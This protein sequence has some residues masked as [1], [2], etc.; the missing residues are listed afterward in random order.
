MQDDRLDIDVKDWVKKIRYEFSY[1]ED[2]MI[3]YR[4]DN[5]DIFEDFQEQKV[6]LNRFIRKLRKATKE[7]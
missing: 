7:E 6:G 3:K 2:L 5:D 4:L 1:L